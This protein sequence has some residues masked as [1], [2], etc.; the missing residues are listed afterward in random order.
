M[1]QSNLRREQI[2][3]VAGALF[4]KRGYHATSVRD[5]AKQLNIQGGSLYAHI[6]SKEDVLWEIIQRA[7]SEFLGG[8]API[9]SYGLPASERLRLMIRA[10]VEIVTHHLDD[11]TVF[12]H[13]WRFLSTE[14]ER[15]VASQR[16]RYEA[17]FRKVI[18]DGIRAGEFREVDAKLAALMTLSSVN[19]V[20]QWYKPDG[21]ISAEQVADG[22]TDLIINGLSAA[23][24]GGNP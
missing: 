6:A 1:A 4:S 10:H 12:F 20:Y 8:V 3:G 15:I 24:T 19:M 23:D 13:E 16:D 21:P 7:A 22:Y 11:A 14:R 18:E 2:Y 17:C 9:A 5:I